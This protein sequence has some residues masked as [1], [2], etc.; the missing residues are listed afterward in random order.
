MTEMITITRSLNGKDYQ[1]RADGID[2]SAE[3]QAYIWRS[4][5]KTDPLRGNNRRV[6]WTHRIG[7]AKLLAYLSEASGGKDAY[8]GRLRTDSASSS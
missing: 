5:C 6:K 8:G 7:L 3:K 4:A 1:F 2:Q